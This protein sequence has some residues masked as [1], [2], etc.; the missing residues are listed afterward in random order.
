MPD[1]QG[2]WSQGNNLETCRA[3]LQDALEGWIIL[4]LRLGHQF[5]TLVY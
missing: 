1:C 4:G 5:P 2:V 3:N